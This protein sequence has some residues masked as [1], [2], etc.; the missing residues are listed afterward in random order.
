MVYLQVQQLTKD[1]AGWK[2]YFEKFSE[3]RK[4]AGEVSCSIFQIPS[5]KNELIILSQWNN[6]EDANEFLDSQSFKM[7]TEKGSKPTIKFLNKLSYKKLSHS[8]K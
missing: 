7:I 2:R 3:Y 4:I 6:L 1:F 8:L 5:N